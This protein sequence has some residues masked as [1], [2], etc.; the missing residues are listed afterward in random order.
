LAKKKTASP[1]PSQDKWKYGHLRLIDNI[2]AGD[3]AIA[4]A[5]STYANYVDTN[6]QSRHWVRAVQWIENILFTSGRH[7]VDDLLVSRLTRDSNN[8]LSIV[9]EATRSIPKPVNDLLGR[10]TE[11]NIALLTENRPRPRVSPKGG[12]AEDEDRAQL[13]EWVLEYLWEALDMPELHREIA[14]MILH[15][16]VCWMEIVHDPTMPR[17]IVTPQTEREDTTTIE[18]PGGQKIIAPVPR[19]V[20]V[21]DEQGNLKF[22]EDVTYGDLSAKVISP[23]EMHMPVAHWWNGEEMDWVMREYYAPVQSLIDKYGSIKRKAG[24]TKKE[25]WHVDVLD[26]VGTT[27]VRNLP[28]WWWERL[29]DLVEGPGPSIYVG[30]PEQWEGYTTVRI[31]DRKPSPDWP[32]GRTIM[33]AGDKVLYDSPKDIGARAYDPR[34]PNRWHPYVRF[35]WE[36]QIGSIYGRSLV[37]KLLPKLKRVNAID[38]TLIMWRRTVPIATWIAP[39]GAHPVEDIWYGQPGGVIE[40]DPRMTAGKAPEPVFPPEYPRTALEER[41]TQIAEMEAIAGT[42][43]ILR[44]QRPAGVTSATMLE[45]LRKQA[46]ASRSSILQAWDE[47][48]QAEGSIMLQEVIKH[49][50]SD[51]RYVEA[52]KVLSMEKQSRRTIENFAGSDI[53]DNVLVRVDTA[54]LALVS[55][56]AREQKVIEIMQYLPNLMSAPPSLQNAIFEELGLAKKLQPQGADINRVKRLMAYIRQGEY[57]RVIPFPE[58]DPYIFFD[59]LSQEM[60]QDSFYNL[61][62]QQQQVLIGLMEMYKLKIQELEAQKLKMQMMMMQQG[63]GGQQGGGQIQ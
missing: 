19:D 32:R 15:C 12:R 29:S 2:P 22:S 63:G 11:T 23:F 49:V 53:S 48:L 40:Y 55:K 61:D 56:E 52:L 1:H 35:R 27:N 10:Y 16:G 60:K 39:K 8:D 59:L 37:S 25:G 30:T 6:R 13:S 31:F 42:E 21:R 9:N 7:Y 3:P 18:G 51:P 17:R 57:D 4:N 41:A 24:L 58:D 34:W 28:I 46:L 26:E 43:E 20:P 14:R 45:V 36:P 5:I 50:K 44:G 33:V 62:N 47:S 54:S 38:T